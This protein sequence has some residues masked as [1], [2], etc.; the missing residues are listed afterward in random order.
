MRIH[1]GHSFPHIMVCK[2]FPN[3]LYVQ[4]VYT[5]PVCVHYVYLFPQL[6][7][8]LVGLLVKASPLTAADPGFDSGLRHGN[9]SRSSHTIGLKIGTPVATLPG[10][11]C[12]MGQRWDWLV[13]CQ[14]TMTF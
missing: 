10:V 9:F 8:C 5:L 11:W 3:S 6:S 14:Y 13:W 2:I 7:G 4:V 1:D 12:Y